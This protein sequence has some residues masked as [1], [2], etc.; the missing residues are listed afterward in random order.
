MQE[1]DLLKA[2]GCSPAPAGL[3][4]FHPGG[5]GLGKEVIPL[6][7]GKVGREQDGVCFALAWMSDT[8]Q[9]P[10]L[11][12]Q[13]KVST[14]DGP[15]GKRRLLALV[16][17]HLGNRVGYS[18]KGWIRLGNRAAS[19]LRTARAWRNASPSPPRWGGFPKPEGMQPLR[20]GRK[21]RPLTQS[22]GEIS[23]WAGLRTRM[24]WPR[25][26]RVARHAAP[27]DAN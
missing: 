10:R 5:R 21:R 8:S 16:W 3:G 7:E 15:G 27:F 20:A 6:D 23:S 9:W 25:L 22:P 2:A 11:G 12:W 1:Q 24:I 13:G 4:G 14:W 17:G 19:P 18:G 26:I